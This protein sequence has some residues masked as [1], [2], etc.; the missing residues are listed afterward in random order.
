MKTLQ[1]NNME[2]KELL[3]FV[4]ASSLEMPNRLRDQICLACDWSKPT[5][6]R[7]LKGN[8][9]ISPAERKMIIQ[10]TDREQKSLL[11]KTAEL[12]KRNP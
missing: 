9:R 6:Y 10:I 12:Y 2:N 1:I 5:F 7:K 8:T 3:P 4:Y 11:A